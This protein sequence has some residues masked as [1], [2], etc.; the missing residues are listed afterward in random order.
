MVKNMPIDIVLIVVAVLRRSFVFLHKREL[1]YLCVGNPSRD[2]FGGFQEGCA[3]LL[4]CKDAQLH[5][6][7]SHH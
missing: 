7:A 2:E 1:T 3:L 6:I 4:R 5:C